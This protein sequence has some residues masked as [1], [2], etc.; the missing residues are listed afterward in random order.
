MA[1][2]CFAI[3]AVVWR[4]GVNWAFCSELQPSITELGQNRTYHLPCGGDG[5]QVM[6]EFGE[7]MDSK[8]YLFIS[9]LSPGKLNCNYVL[10]F[11]TTHR[12]SLSYVLAQCTRR[13]ILLNIFFLC[14]FSSERTSCFVLT[15]IFIFGFVHDDNWISACL[16]WCLHSFAPRL[17]FYYAA[18]L[19][20]SAVPIIYLNLF[21]VIPLCILWSVLPPVLILLPL[22]I[23]ICSCRD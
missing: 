1:Q 20:C 6:S 5:F 2:H 11:K 7:N 19:T 15:S 12:L 17:L 13:S 8:F 18:S 16:P 10:T 9:Y 3:I 21:L 14:L 4:L 23:I 22:T